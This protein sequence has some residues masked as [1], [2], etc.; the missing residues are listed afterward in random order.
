[1]ITRTS[2]R[3]KVACFRYSKGYI[4]ESVLKNC[5]IYVPPRL[6]SVVKIYPASKRITRTS[7]SI[8]NI[9]QAH[10]LIQNVWK[11]E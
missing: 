8:K 7:F 1:M 11:L 3:R 6:Q 4:S 5:L 2:S 10:L 9:L